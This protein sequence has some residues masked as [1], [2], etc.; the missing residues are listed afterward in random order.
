MSHHRLIAPVAAIAVGVAF[1]PGLAH[2]A[3][4]A[5]AATKTGLTTP[6]NT[7]V[8]AST[9]FNTFTSPA[10]K[11][12]RRLQASS[13]TVTKNAVTAASG[14]TIYVGNPL[15]CPFVSSVDPG[16][17]TAAN[18]Y[19]R[20]QD[21]VDAA[22][23]GDTVSVADGGS[24]TY[25]GSV[26]ITTSDIS[27]VGQGTQ[28]W[29]R[30]A[31]GV[32]AFVLEG[33]SNV[34]ITNLIVSVSG[35]PAFEVIGSTGVTL[36][37][38]SLE[39]SYFNVPADTVTIDGASSGVTVSRTYVNTDTG[40]FGRGIS[41]AA[42]AKNITLASDII[43]STGITAT[44]VSGLNVVGDTIQRACGPAIDVEG[45]STEVHLENNLLE[46]SNPGIP[47]FGDQ[48]Q[49]AAASLAWSPDITVAP[50][51]SAATTADYNDFYI[52]G[53]D[54]TAPYE[55]AGTT[56]PTLSAFQSGTTQAAHDT[57]DSVEALMTAFRPNQGSDV[58][59][60]LRLGSAA[61][62]SANLQAPG[63]LSSDFLGRGPYKSRGAL[64]VITP[65][66]Q[67]AVA[68]SG[69]DTS[70]FGIS[71]TADITSIVIPL[72]VTFDWGDSTTTSASRG[73]GGTLALPHTYAKPGKYT[74]TVTITDN[75][76]DTVS[77]TVSATTAGS[78]Y[79][80]YGPVR[81]LDTRTGT[82]TGGKAGKV[83]GHGT[84]KVKV[85]GAGAPGNPIPSGVTAVVINLTVTNPTAAGFVTAYPNEDPGG[86]GQTAPPTSNVNFASG[87]TV[88]NL[89]VVP[90]GADGI[91][92][93]Y[94]ASV[95][96]ADLIADVTGYFSHTAAGGFTPLGPSRLVDTRN[97]T[98]GHAGKIAAHGTDLVQVAGANSGTLPGTGVTAVA[99][100]VTIANPAGSGF[101]TVYPD[102]IATPNASNL[103]FS[104]GQTVANAVVV[105]VGADGK[106][107]LYNGSPTG[108]TDVV[109]DV[110]GYYSAAS[111]SAYLPISPLR[112]YDT[113]TAGKGKLPKNY[114]LPLDFSAGDPSITGFVLN[115]TVTN[116]AGSG[117]LT[118]APDPNTLDQYGNG[119]ATPPTPPN[120]SSLNWGPGMTVPNLVQADGGSTGI[121]DFFN[122]G[123]TGAV[124]LVV[125]VFG[126][127]QND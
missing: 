17:G 46:D 10:G 113:R 71:L 121:I 7:G 22:S 91:V 76:G 75:Q 12:V 20:I 80:P 43:A 116:P 52:H 101:L 58:D 64:Q 89:T 62:N 111:T 65:D 8:D 47:I 70:A 127:Y 48:A 83:A 87:Q 5:Q 99:L 45:A 102:G 19:C 38:S 49:C 90:V 34:T 18:P 119:S 27:I 126:Y 31:S 103:N 84:L 67:L 33:V 2:A 55:W 32:P 15:S 112:F 117:F 77:N 14:A 95:N 93:L 66:P 59:A 78:D 3:S 25:Q 100:N 73:N 11:S 109:V 30:A 16:T 4:S 37:S 110:V 122:L 6:V 35:A 120:S 50:G 108:G 29:E 105:P 92:D 88:P 79:S 98:G 44:D 97:G 53:S 82:G 61:I 54:A 104:R 69:S 36:D 51:S 56:Y 24:Y 60:I 13:H 81:I 106:I 124:D 74:V 40:A 107:R 86:A 115:T 94:N 23:A 96:G 72:S 57:L 125:D 42:G 1:I 63:E 26:K 39:V 123:G 41:I 21:A 85:A 28:A 114:Y 68:L 118:V 9:S